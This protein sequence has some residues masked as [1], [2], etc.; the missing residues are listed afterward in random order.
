MGDNFEF[1]TKLWQ[2]SESSYGTTIPQNILAIKNAPVENGE[3]VWS[4]NPDTGKVEVEFQERE[5]D[6]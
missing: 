3:V 6:G 2:R 5:E 1:T 4:I